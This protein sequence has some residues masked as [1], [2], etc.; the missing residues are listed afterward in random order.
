MHVW[1]WGHCGVQVGQELEDVLAERDALKTVNQEL[2][3]RLC[4]E[5]VAA[6]S[7]A[8]N[9]HALEVC[10]CNLVIF[11]IAKHVELAKDG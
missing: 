10:W 8:A 6:D 1:L 7:S 4:G 11:L 3:K 9:Q 2:A 5:L